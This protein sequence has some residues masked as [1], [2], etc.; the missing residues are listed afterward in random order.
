MIVVMKPFQV[1]GVWDSTS[2]NTTLVSAPPRMICQLL[3]WPLS[4]SP[5]LHSFNKHLVPVMGSYVVLDSG[6]PNKVLP[7]T[8]LMF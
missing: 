1:S 7:L 8:E 2:K 5:T 3:S 4:T 6:D